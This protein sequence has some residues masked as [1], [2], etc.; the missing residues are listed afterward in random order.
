LDPTNEK[1]DSDKD[2]ES[3]FGIANLDV[4]P[5]VEKLVTYFEMVPEN[6]REAFEILW[7]ERLLRLKAAQWRKYYLK[8][9]REKYSGAHFFDGLFY[10]NQEIRDGSLTVGALYQSQRF[11]IGKRII[12]NKG[13]TSDQKLYNLLLFLDEL[14]V[15]S[16]KYHIEKNWGVTASAHFLEEQRL[17]QDVDIG[18]IKFHFLE[19][20]GEPKDEKLKGHIGLLLQEAETSL[21]EAKESIKSDNKKYKAKKRRKKIKKIK[22]VGSHQQNPDEKVDTGTESSNDK[23]PK[24]PFNPSTQGLL[25]VRNPKIGGVE[26]DISAEACAATI[27]KM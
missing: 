22:A 7:K 5:H 27:K 9:V 10:G 4:T 8:R 2:L 21:E 17:I 25:A 11:K 3:L 23:Y 13:L 1:I 26:E 14:I 15:L 16:R 18:M 20:L 12:L 24:A 6:H 19:A